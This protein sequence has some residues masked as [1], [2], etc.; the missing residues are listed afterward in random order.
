MK[1][2][3]KTGVVIGLAITML[4]TQVTAGTV[5]AATDET[6]TDEVTTEE[7]TTEEQ[8]TE[9]ITTD[10]VT[11]EEISTEELEPEN[12]ESEGELA[13]DEAHFPDANFRSY[14]KDSVDTDKNGA[15]SQEERDAC[16]VISVGYS[17]IQSLAGIEYFTK[18][19][20]LY[21]ISN[22]LSNLNINKNLNLR[23]VNCS[24]NQMSSLDVSNN[25]NLEEFQ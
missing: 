6:T 3:R 14:I 13:I 20:K 24:Y 7:V 5:M 17:E 18:L 9:E 19:E 10:E 1:Q 8:S 16:T 4:M 25:P 21:C 11:T 12:K 23:V 2:I 22:K 15:L